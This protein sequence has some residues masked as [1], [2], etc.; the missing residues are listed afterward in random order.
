M[1]PRNLLLPLREAVGDTP[2]VLV[3]GARQVGK[4]TL[5]QA[6]ADSFDA[7]YLTLDDATVLAAARAAPAE[8]LAGLSGSVI[9]DEVQRAPE[10]FIALKAAVDRDRRPGRFLLTGSANVLMLPSVSESLAGRMEVLTLWPL[11]QGEL[12]GTREGFIDALFS[13]ELPAFPGSATTREDLVGRVLAGGFPEA[14]ARTS[15]RRRRAWFG[16]Y[17]TTI[18]QRDVRDIANI[19]GLSDLP[20]LL[21][22]LAARAGGL[23]NF[24]ELSRSAGIAQSTLKRYMTLLEMTFLISPLHAWSGN[25][26]KRLIKAPKLMLTDTGL[27]AYL[28]GI[29]AAPGET[30]SGTILGSMFENF[31]AAELRK[32][33]GWSEVQP[34]LYHYRTATNQEVDFLLEDSRG[35]VTAIE[36]KAKG[37]VSEH[38]FRHLKHLSELLGKR[39]IHG[40]VLYTGSEAVSFGTSLTALPM[41]ALWELGAK[42]SGH[43]AEVPG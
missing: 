2:V 20:R 19:E 6:L 1:Y 40:V 17:V 24:A 7:R 11:S 4:S 18:L 42:P 38:D 26:G 33:I 21:A 37:S 25:F 3:N 39:F 10:L 34:R 35:R 5:V 27:T 9:I 36:V 43:G 28:L 16:S 13:R 23:L 31:V 22:L 29:D 30:E 15:V 14:I 12:A 32:Q 8:F 41:S